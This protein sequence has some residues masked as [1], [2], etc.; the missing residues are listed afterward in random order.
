MI[1]ERPAFEIARGGKFTWTKK[2]GIGRQSQPEYLAQLCKDDTET[3][4]QLEIQEM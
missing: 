2:K 4:F 1:R 3:W